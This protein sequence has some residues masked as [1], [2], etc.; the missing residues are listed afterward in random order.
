MPIYPVPIF[1]GMIPKISDNWGHRES[2]GKLHAGADMAY[3]RPKTGKQLLP[4][5]T[6]N[7]MM[8]NGVP[9]LAYDGGV[10]TKS[11]KIRTGGRVEI[12]HGNG[13]STHYLHLRN[14]RM[15]VGDKVSAGQPVGTIYH[16]IDGYKWNHLHFGMMQNG[17]L[18]DPA[19][20][21]A[22]ATKVEAPDNAGFLL[23]V[24]LA[25]GAGL[26]IN[27]YVFK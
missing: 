11:G 7:Y 24:G 10:V 26:L 27:K 16:N 4:V 17:R 20:H 15:K 21:L 19:N 1:R 8:P 23:N 5:Y 6:K 18:F 3:R 22:V 12:N 2:S 13:L 14:I 9:A 25:I